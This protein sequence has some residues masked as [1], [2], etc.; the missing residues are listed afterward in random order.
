M[1]AGRHASLH[2]RDDLVQQ[3]RGL[4]LVVPLGGGEPQAELLADDLGDDGAHGGRPQDLLRLSLELRL[5]HGDREH[6]GEAGENVVLLQ[7]VVADLQ[8]A[9]VLIDLA[10]KDLQQL[11]LEPLLMRP[12]FGRRDDVDERPDGRVVAGSP[13]QGD[14]HSALTLDLGR[15]HRT[16]GLQDGD[17]LGEHA[18]PL[19]PPGV[20]DRGVGGEIL[21]ELADPALIVVGGLLG[22]VGALV[23]DDDLEPGDEEG[24]LT[25]TVLQVRQLELGVLREDLPI[26]PIADPRARH[27]PCGL[28]HHTQLALLLERCER[29]VR[30][31]TPLVGEDTRLAAVEGHRIRLAA[32]IDLDVQPLRER[33][34]DGG[35]HTVQ[36]AGGRIG[37]SAE[38]PASVQLGVHD[39]DA[40][41]PR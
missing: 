16:I 27:A 11:L 39:L 41:Q 32:A 13:A 1:R 38:L 24:R 6:R 19:Q 26:R 7:L 9:G 40:S 25:R 23:S 12:A 36:P 2:L 4:V 17:G 20:G 22:V 10:A 31:R 18:A 34:H 35:A 29:R 3:H 21:H 30:S 33:V 37:P 5:R 28:A 14:V 8:P 15:A